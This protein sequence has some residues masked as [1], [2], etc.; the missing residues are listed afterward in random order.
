MVGCKVDPWAF[1]HQ[2][3]KNLD[4]ALLLKSVAN[5]FVAFQIAHAKVQLLSLELFFKLTYF[6]DDPKP[7]NCW[8]N[9]AHI[10]V[11]DGFDL[12]DKIRAHFEHFLLESAHVC[13]G[14]IVHDM[15]AVVVCHQDALRVGM[16][17]DLVDPTQQALGLTF[18]W[19]CIFI[20]FCFC[21]LLLPVYG[22][23]ESG[24]VLG[25]DGTSRED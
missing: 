16:L 13:E 9:V 15:E 1:G 25:D 19:V 5:V 7:I 22:L 14:R 2:V 11:L 10:F 23:S 6:F 18:L 8:Q 21:S 17:L 20:D 24:V 3:N 12:V 4:R